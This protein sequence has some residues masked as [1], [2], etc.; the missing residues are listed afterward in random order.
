M[1]A[2]LFLPLLASLFLIIGLGITYWIHSRYQMEIAVTPGDLP[3]DLV[4]PLIS[5]VVPARDEERNIRACI[6]SLL[7]QT[8]PRF[9][10]IAVD[11]RSSDTTPRILAE[12]AL[13][14]GRL[15]LVHGS[16]P[17]PGWKGKPH[18]L[19]QAA[20]LAAGEWLCFVDADTFAS[21][22]LLASTYTAAKDQSADMFSIM[23]TQILGSFWEK[24]LLPV[25]FTGLSFGFPAAAVNDPKNPIAI[26]NGQFILIKRK[27]YQAVGGHQ[28]VRNRID[29]DKALAQLVKGAGHRLI[30]ADGRSLAQTRM[31]TSLSE[32]W[33][34]WTKNIYLGMLDRLWLLLFGAILGLIGALVLPVW[35][36]TGLVWLGMGGGFPA[37]LVTGQAALLW[38]YLLWKRAQ[39]ARAFEI[40]PLY[41][42]SLPLGALVF[43]AMMGASAFKVLSGQG[44]TWKGRTY[45]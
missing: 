5:V 45:S 31:Y 39:V 29:E 20:D 12:M 15:H 24:V 33:Q 32:M 25:V 17:P 16:E 44:V 43:T 9:E 36:I 38:A 1:N 35:L 34:G 22:Y 11:D 26:A 3:S 18:A 7:A 19:A 41:A 4:P 8:Y 40:S 6:E 42:F 2:N 13:H 21:P 37:V 23:T 14:D 27:V 30:I 28:A 10:V